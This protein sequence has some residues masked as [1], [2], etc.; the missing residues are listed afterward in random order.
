M[1]VVLGMIS[2]NEEFLLSKTLPLIRDCFDGLLA[3]DSYSTD[4]TPSIVQINKGKIRYRKWNYNFSDARNALIKWAEAEKYDWIFMLDTDEAMFPYNIENI[5]KY[6]TKENTFIILPRIEF[7][8]DFNHY[9][10]KL[11]PDKQGRIFKLN[12]GYHFRTKVHELLFKGKDTQS[13]LQTGYGIFIPDCPIYHYGE[14]KPK[15]VVWLRWHNY[16][17]IKEG[18]LPLKKPPKNLPKDFTIRKEGEL[19][20]FYGNHPLKG[21]K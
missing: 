5:K 7:C 6:I 10:P 11:Y 18:K 21:L 15:E 8:Q 12:I 19:E 16:G 2:F 17:R 4:S 9:V 14:C 1:K 13:A 20:Y 3:L